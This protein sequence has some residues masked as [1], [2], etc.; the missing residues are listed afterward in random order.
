MADSLA[1][2]L[3]SKGVCTDQLVITVGYDIENMASSAA[4]AAGHEIVADAYGRRMP[5]QAHGSISLDRY[6]S[7]GER[8]L[9]AAVELF[10][11]IVDP[12]LTVR[13]LYVVAYHVIPAEQ[14]PRNDQE[15]QLSM[16]SDPEKEQNEKLEE[17][18]LSQELSM[19]EAMLAIR[20]RFGKNAILK[21]MNLEEG[22]TTVKRHG[23][24]GGHRA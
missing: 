23:Q 2:D 19:Q 1:L 24:I 11:R 14:I 4:G 10:T 6:T 18:R 7:S 17:E 20:S 9:K 8:I 13:R 21:G 5:R 12:A 15:Q 16:F 22:A 3:V